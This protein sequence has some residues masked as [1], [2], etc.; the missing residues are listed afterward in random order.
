M[1]FSIILCHWKTGMMTAYT[2]S[3]VLKYKGRHEVD[4]LVLNNNAGDGS[5]KY[6]EPFMDQINY[7]E[8]PKDMMQSHGIGYDVLF[9]LA[10]TEWVICLESDSF[11][12]KYGW[13]DYYEDL[14]N[15]DYHCAGSLLKL[16]GGTYI[17]PAGTLYNKDVYAKGW[18]YCK[19]IAYHYFPNMAMKE[20]FQCHLMVRKDICNDFLR[21][22]EDYI[23]LADGYKPYYPQ[24]AEKKCVHYLPV[25]GPFHNG[26]GKNQESIHTYGFR[27]MASEAQNVLLDNKQKIIKRIGAEPGQWFAWWQK[28]MGYSIYEIPTEVHWLPG[29]ENQQQEYTLTENG[30]KHLWGISAYHGV[31]LND[32]DVAKVKQSIPE[33][34]YNSLPEYQKIKDGN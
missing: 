31:T 34:L 32:E 24:L 14:I 12:T 10:K 6:L 27:T 2:I 17:H 9:E 22:P 4:I 33:Q 21:E 29:K 19:E 13:L 7:F 28:A 20:G 30:V 1:K 23:E 5:E 26:M 15:I 25:V 16:S 8:Y 11:P 18:A 3:Q